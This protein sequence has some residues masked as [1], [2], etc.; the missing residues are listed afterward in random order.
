M[1][2]ADETFKA[3]DSAIRVREIG[4][5]RTRI[6]VGQLRGL[7]AMMELAELAE[8]LGPVVTRLLDAN[9]RLEAEN[10]GL[11]RRVLELEKPQ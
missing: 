6:V 9:Q 11:V 2:T 4:E 1:L 8:V 7:D 5:E 3:R 10:R